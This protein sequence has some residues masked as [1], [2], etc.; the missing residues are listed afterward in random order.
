MRLLNKHVQTSVNLV[1][2]LEYSIRLW[3]Y[4]YVAAREWRLRR[5]LGESAA[6]AVS[7]PT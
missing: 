3:R 1:H 2:Y 7:T 5:G 4:R 6:G